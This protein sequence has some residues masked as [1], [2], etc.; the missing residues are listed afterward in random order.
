MNNPK[1]RSFIDKYKS[2]R[3]IGEGRSD[4]ESDKYKGAIKKKKKGNEG[5]MDVKTNE[6]D[7][8]DG[9]KVCFSMTFFY[10]TVDLNYTVFELPVR[11]QT[12]KEK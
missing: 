1:H 6:N 5:K 8:P 4:N 2:I 10:Y 11:C 7:D 9:A 3:H 12:K